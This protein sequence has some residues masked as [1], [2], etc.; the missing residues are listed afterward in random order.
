[1]TFFIIGHKVA[2][3]LGCFCKKNCHQSLS[4]V[5]QSGH[6]VSDFDRDAE[7]EHE[8]GEQL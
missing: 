6:T 7:Q 5:A 3:Y 1:M 2:K 8:D 4:K